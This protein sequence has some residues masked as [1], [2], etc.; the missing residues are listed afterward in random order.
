MTEWHN[1][2]GPGGFPKPSAE[3]EQA[4]IDRWLLKSEPDD[5]ADVLAE[6]R[7]KVLSLMTSRGDMDGLE[8]V[9][10]DDVLELID[11]LELRG[12]S[13]NE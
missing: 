10:L 13:Q 6:L 8:Y 11:L 1:V 3:Y 5:V 12:G 7:D 2:L 9:R 4:E